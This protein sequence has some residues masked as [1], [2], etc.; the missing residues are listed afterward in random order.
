LVPGQIG[1]DENG[2]PIPG[3]IFYA[4]A[5]THDAGILDFAF[6]EAGSSGEVPP[7][8]SGPLRVAWRPGARLALAAFAP[9]KRPTVVYDQFG[10]VDADGIVLSLE[11]LSEGVM[12][13]ESRV[14]K[15]A[16]PFAGRA[17]LTERISR[18][19][20]AALRR[21]FLAVYE[22]VATKEARPTPAE[23]DKYQVLKSVEESAAP[24]K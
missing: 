5:Y 15:L 24:A 14:A 21:A 7:A 16:F 22:P 10:R 17:D 8:G 19:D 11:A 18:P 1:V 20:A 9:G 2:E 3:A 13:W 4:E 23:W 12:R 6:A